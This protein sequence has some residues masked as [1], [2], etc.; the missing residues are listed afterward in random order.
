VIG[1]KTWE[2]VLLFRFEE[3]RGDSRAR[4]H[5]ESLGKTDKK[6]LA[7]KVWGKETETH[8]IGEKSGRGKIKTL[9]RAG[10]G[11]EDINGPGVGGKDRDRPHRESPLTGSLNKSREKVGMFSVERPNQTGGGILAERGH[12]TK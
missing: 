5:H 7:V 3:I 10:G 2:V 11:I 9:G 8:G 1:T 12:K 4:K 6:R